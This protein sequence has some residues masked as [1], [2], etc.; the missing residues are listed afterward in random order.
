MQ[1]FLLDVLS[2]QEEPSV[3][4]PNGNNSAII[5]QANF[6]GHTVRQEQGM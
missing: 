4:D 3:N 6:K 5:I 1:F 2:I